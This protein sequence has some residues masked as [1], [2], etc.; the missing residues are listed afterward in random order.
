M[1]EISGLDCEGEAISTIWVKPWHS[2]LLSISKYSVFLNSG[3]KGNSSGLNPWIWFLKLLHSIYKLCLFSSNTI[4]SLGNKDIKFER[5]LA[6]TT[7]L[8]FL[9]ILV[10]IHNFI[11][12]S[13]SVELKLKKLSSVFIK[14][15]S[16]IGKD[17]F[18]PT[19]F[20]TTFKPFLKFSF[21][22]STFI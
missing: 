2:F 19:I 15:L 13:K 18:L 9:I 5:N 10:K 3:I 17:K 12:V 6:G 21:K 7:T 20:S 11:A 16:K 4:F 14:T 22:I 8:P 1:P